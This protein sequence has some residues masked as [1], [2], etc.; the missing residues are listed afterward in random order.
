MI[1]YQRS[2]GNEKLKQVA[3]E[4]L[5]EGSKILKEM[6]SYDIPE[7][8]KKIWRDIAGRR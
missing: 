3:K 6:V 1:E 2:G 8:I 5:K 4:D 7:T